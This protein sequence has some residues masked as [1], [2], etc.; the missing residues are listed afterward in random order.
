[1]NC[2]SLKSRFMAVRFMIWDL[3][4]YLDT[5]PDDTQAAGLLQQYASQYSELLREY[6]QKYGPLTASATGYGDA[7]LQPAW[8]WDLTKEGC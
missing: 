2:E 6:E 1:M 5:H 3:H 8:P 4:L 7:W